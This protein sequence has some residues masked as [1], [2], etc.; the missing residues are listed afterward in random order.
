[1]HLFSLSISF[2]AIQ[3]TSRT[4]TQD[5]L[6]TNFH[7]NQ[8]LVINPLNFEIL[9]G[10][11]R[12]ISVTGGKKPYRYKV[13]AG[14]GAINESGAFSSSTPGS[15]TL[16]IDDSSGLGAIA[17]GTVRAVGKDPANLTAILSN[18]K[19][20]LKADSFALADGNSVTSW[21]DSSGNGVAVN[22]GTA[23]NQP[24]YK[25]SV[26]NGRPAVRFDG[27]DDRLT[28][29]FPLPTD[30]TLFVVATPSTVTNS[31]M[32]AGTAAGQTPA[33]I[34]Q[35][36]TRAYEYFSQVGSTER[37]LIQGVASGLNVLTVRQIGTTN[38]QIF[39]NGVLQIS[40][41]PTSGLTGSSF[42]F[43]GSTSAPASWY[44]G[45]IAEILT[46]NIPLSETD[47]ISVEC[48]LMK[49]FGIATPLCQ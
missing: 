49:K 13:F 27:V 46:Y 34:S 19:L 15:A 10:E 28:L 9:N 38:L 21:A 3:C 6:D 36:S 23:A 12:T 26:Y 18:L 37:L 16:Q 33:I 7:F 35:W 17:T 39:Y 42:N 22:Q 29:T 14:V 30:M 25:A 11:S 41:T 4:S 32:I 45:D 44:G 20:W 2:L 8:P 1:M 24:L 43:I 47:R 48:S 31:Y 5:L 40:T